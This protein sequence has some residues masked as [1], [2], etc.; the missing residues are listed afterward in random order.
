MTSIFDWL[1]SFAAK[2]LAVPELHAILVAFAIGCALTYATAHMMPARWRSSTAVI[3]SRVLIVAAVMMVATMQVPTPVMAGWAFTVGV[4][5]P[6]VYEMSLAA[7]W[8]R[9]PWIKP[10]AMLTAPEMLERMKKK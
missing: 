4:L 2:V 3:L 6:P 5:T 9:W 8:H 10:K 1:F 7:L